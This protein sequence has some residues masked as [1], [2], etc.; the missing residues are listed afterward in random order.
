MAG[1]PELMLRLLSR[2]GDDEGASGRC[3]PACPPPLPVGL[4][5]VPC[6]RTLTKCCVCNGRVLLSGTWHEPCPSCRAL[7]A[8]LPPPLRPVEP[9]APVKIAEAGPRDEHELT[10][11]SAEAPNIG[12][13]DRRR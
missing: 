9:G 2:S 3:S 11:R 4:N 10:E 13:K 5:V 7:V 1:V 6:V 12:T 8:C